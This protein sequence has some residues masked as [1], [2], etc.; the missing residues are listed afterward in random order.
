MQTLPTPRGPRSA[1]LM[2]A[3][4]AGIGHAG[5]PAFADPEDPLEDDD[6]Q[7]A[8]Y[9]CYELHYR[10]IVGVE[11]DLEW[12]PRV[13]SFRA[14]LEKP[15]ERALRRATG[16]VQ[17]MTAPARVVTDALLELAVRDARPSLSRYLAREA[18]VD[19]FREFVKHRSL[20]TLKEADPHSFV[21]ARLTGAVKSALL[22]IQADE[23][24]AGRPDRM[25]S[26]IFARTMRGLGLDDSYGAYLDEM[27]GSTLATINLVSYLSLHRRLRGAAMGHLALFELT[28]SV[29]NRRYGNG[30]RRLGFGPEVTDYYDEH[31]EADA[32]HDMIAT[33]DVV[34][35]LVREEPALAG[36][37][38][39]GARALA[40]LEDRFAD[41]LLGAW[42]VRRSDLDGVQV[43]A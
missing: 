36:D 12:D 21:I 22:E 17:P 35:Q 9:L 32:V 41:H 40:L 26:S 43:P 4:R 2:T 31:V 34:G 20:Y 13:L 7:Q 23:Y 27:P 37:A 25:H 38:L 19:E 14:Q 8:L 15:F 1:A 6:L 11:P 33:H 5:L 10:G 24:G 16:S 42:R 28:S 30:L 39:F 29:A 3:L 18:S